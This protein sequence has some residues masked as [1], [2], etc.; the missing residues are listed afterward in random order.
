MGVFTEWN[1]M[2]YL[3]NG[4][5]QIFKSGFP[6]SGSQSGNILSRHCHR[7][8]EK[9]YFSDLPNISSLFQRRSPIEMDIMGPHP[10]NHNAWKLLKLLQ[11]RRNIQRKSSEAFQYSFLNGLYQFGRSYDS[12][13]PP[14]SYQC[15]TLVCLLYFLSYGFTS[16]IPHVNVNI[17]DTG[18]HKRE[19]TKKINRG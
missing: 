17:R 10:C 5:Q 1:G 11:S 18:L 19:N 9:A 7:S 12:P 14:F 6:W 3:Q 8:R 15:R 2:E 4:N 13:T 16:D